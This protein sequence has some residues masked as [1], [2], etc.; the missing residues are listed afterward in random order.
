[1]HTIYRA[2]NKEPFPVYRNIASNH[3]KELTKIGILKKETIGKE[4]VFL[5]VGLYELLTRQ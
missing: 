4:V 3:L 5:N 2:R 1:L